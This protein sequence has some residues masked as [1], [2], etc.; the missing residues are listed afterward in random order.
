MSSREYLVEHQILTYLSNLGIGFFW[1]NASGGFYDG[2]KWRKH[3]SP[4]AIR[5]TSDILGIIESQ[6]GRFCA[7]EVKD[8]GE[9]T[10]E[11]LAFIRKVRAL[12]GIGAVVRSC[13]QAREVLESAGLSIGESLHAHAI[14]KSHT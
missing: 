5:G 8:E 12:G 2:T 9:P 1:K 14:S 7:L 3:T 6:G 4:F 13:D 11:Q 10:S